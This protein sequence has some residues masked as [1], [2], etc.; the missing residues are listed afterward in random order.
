[1]TIREENLIAYEGSSKEH[2]SA[3]EPLQKLFSV[4]Y[5]FLFKKINESYNY[6][7]FN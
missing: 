3:A 7:D 6:I 1:M 4:C 5:T 2:Q